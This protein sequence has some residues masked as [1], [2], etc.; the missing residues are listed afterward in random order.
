MCL[1][2]HRARWRS[3]SYVKRTGGNVVGEVA[4]EVV[5]SGMEAAAVV[6]IANEATKNELSEMGFSSKY[7]DAIQSQKESIEPFKTSRM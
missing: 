7:V 6:A 4:D 1:A 5:F 2:W 3:E